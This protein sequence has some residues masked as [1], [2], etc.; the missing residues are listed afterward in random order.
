[1]GIANHPMAG[2]VPGFFAGTAPNTQP[3]EFA[4]N[5]SYN[6]VSLQWLMLT[7]AYV[8]YGV[9][10]T[11]VDQPVKDALKGGVRIKSAQ[12]DEDDI[13]RLE[14]RLKKIKY[15]QKVQTAMKWARLYGG[16]GF[17]INVNEDFSKEF[18]VSVLK[19]NE[20]VDFKVADRWQLTYNGQP[21]KVGTTFRLQDSNA[22]SLIIHPSRVIKVRG[23]EAPWQASQR[24]MGWDMSVIECVIRE[25]NSNLKHDNVAFEYLDEFKVDVWKVKGFNSSALSK[26]ALGQLTKRFQLAQQVKNFLNAVVLDS[27]DDFDQKQPTIAG[28]SDIMNHLMVKMAAAARMPMSKIYGLSAQGFASGEDDLENY[29]AIV[30]DTRTEVTDVLDCTLPVICMAEWGFVPDDLSYEFKPA[31]TLKAVDQEEINS[32]KHLRHKENYQMGILTA[33]EYVDQEKRDGLI[34]VKTAVEDGAE[35]QP[36]MLSSVDEDQEGSNS[37]DE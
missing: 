6:L 29:S 9:F 22:Q 26:L 28:L 12:V 15:W 1:M 33:Q 4:F 10:R 23:I 16:A 2:V 8:A 3:F 11:I 18:D 32:K 25:F 37:N 13:I 24:L 35:P 7:Y 14:R 19:Q 36:P 5:L 20:N 21:G 31:R 34:T 17:V 27:E 30:E